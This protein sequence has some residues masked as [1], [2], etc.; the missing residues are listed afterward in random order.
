MKSQGNIFDL[1]GTLLDSMPAWENIGTDFLTKHGVNPPADLNKIIKT[2]SFVES[3]RYFIDFFG[4]DMTVEQ[5]NDEINAMIQDNYAKHLQLKPFVK[6]VLDQQRAKG[7]KMG[8][9]TATH[10]S[11]VELVLARF[12]L[13]NHFQFILTSGMAGL[14]KSDPE[15]YHKAIKSLRLPV[16]QITIFE[17]A[18]YCI[19][20]ARNTG[21]H[22]VGVYDESS[23][24]DWAEIQKNAD[25]TIL[26]F[27]ELL[28]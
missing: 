8:I 16:D 22:I 19:Q 7:I 13:L 24:A 6:E 3:S 27:K 17:D 25:D 5:V 26:S 23:K 4:V 9:L 15:I 12:G 28:K 20:A 11:L 14:P 1:D 21:C 18:L 10:K 2:M